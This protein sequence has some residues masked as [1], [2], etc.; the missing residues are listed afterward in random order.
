MVT[1]K[2]DV[3]VSL[4]TCLKLFPIQESGDCAVFQEDS[5]AA[6][7]TVGTSE[8]GRKLWERADMLGM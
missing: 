7:P 3:Y 4:H 2:C 6:N 5:S 8:V 1:G